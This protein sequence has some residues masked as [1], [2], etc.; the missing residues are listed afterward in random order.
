MW[1]V[2]QG[3]EV[4]TTEHGRID[5]A[6]HVGSVHATGASGLLRLLLAEHASKVVAEHVGVHDAPMSGEPSQRASADRQ[7]RRYI[8]S[9]ERAVVSVDSKVCRAASDDAMMRLV[10]HQ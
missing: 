10:E 3:A 4:E 8:E 6:A 1:I 9:R 5:T 2:L 7:G